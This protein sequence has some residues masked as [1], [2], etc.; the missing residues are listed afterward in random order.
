MS[1]G[2]RVTEGLLGLEDPDK[3][4][5]TDFSTREVSYSNGRWTVSRHRSTLRAAFIMVR[6]HAESFRIEGEG[7]VQEAE[8]LAR[9][10]EAAAAESCAVPQVEDE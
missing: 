2:D 10:L 6:G 3:I 7:Y 1:T 8:G 9:L 4:T 5:R